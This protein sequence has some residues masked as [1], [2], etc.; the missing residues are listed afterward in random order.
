MSGDS[1]RQRP[2][3]FKTL[4][5]LGYVHQAFSI[6]VVGADLALLLGQGALVRFAPIV[7]VLVIGLLL[8]VA[9]VIAIFGVARRKSPLALAWLRILLWVGVAKGPIAGLWL[10]GR[11][12]ADMQVLFMTMIATEAVLIPVAIYWSR[13]AHSKYLSSLKAA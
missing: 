7:I 5:V 9:A 1:S 2:L 10:M 3:G 11:A 12:D 8:A 6:A 13:P 4:L